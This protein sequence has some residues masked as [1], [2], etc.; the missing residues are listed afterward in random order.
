MPA[1]NVRPEVQKSITRLLAV[2]PR[3]ER[4]ICERA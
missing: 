3:S 1:E 2:C 4:G